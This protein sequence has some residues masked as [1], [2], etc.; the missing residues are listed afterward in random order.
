MGPQTLS[1]R[2]LIGERL[3]HYRIIERI[4]AGAMGEVYRALDEHLD[5]EVAIKVLLAERIW[6]DCESRGAFRREAMTLSHL[7]HPNI[8]TVHDFDCAG[9]TDFLVSEYVT[10]CSL[11][12]LL[13]KNP[14][15]EMEI[16]RLS[17]QLA[18]GIAA[19]HAQGVVHRD[20]KPT[21]LRLTPDGRLKILD[22]G[23]ARPISNVRATRSTDSAIET[24]GISGTLADMAPE[25]LRGEQPDTR[26]D[27]YSVGVVLYEMATGRRPF[28]ASLAPALID[29][30]FHETPVRPGRIRP[31]LST[32]LEQIILKCLEK[33]PAHRYQTALELAT[34]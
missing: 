10:G 5:R 19:A 30:I 25:Q 33:D 32:A 17:V 21:N 22:F 4:G 34:D 28:T 1:T 29:A 3:G 12:E 15:P 26:S 13:G 27:I 16:L 9:E 2:Q 31:E 20:L 14:L 8:A 7:N 6:S 11:D 23:L 24:G 18:A